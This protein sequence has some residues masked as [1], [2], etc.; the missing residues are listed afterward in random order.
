MELII[1]FIQI[2][3]VISILILLFFWFLNFALA[4]L[5]FISIINFFLIKLFIIKKNSYTNPN[6]SLIAKSI[7]ILTI[8]NLFT[9]L[10]SII[11]IL[12][13]PIF[14]VFSIHLWL[15][16][17]FNAYLPIKNLF[18]WKSIKSN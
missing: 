8:I 14:S 18:L 6:N 16:L 15:I 1:L 11:Y 13:L 3:V 12:H 4:N 17:F 10:S 9:I 2:I 7:N 5:L